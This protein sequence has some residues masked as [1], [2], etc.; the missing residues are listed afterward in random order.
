MCFWGLNLGIGVQD[1]HLTP[2]TMLKFINKDTV[3][4]EAP[5]EET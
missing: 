2:A 3:K 5:T 4:V 1:K